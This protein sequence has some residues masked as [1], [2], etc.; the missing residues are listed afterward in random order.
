MWSAAGELRG[1][2]HA[3]RAP[4]TRV[5]AVP[6]DPAPPLHCFSGQGMS[7]A[8]LVARAVGRQRPRRGFWVVMVVAGDQRAPYP[9]LRGG[10]H[11]GLAPAKRHTRKTQ[12]AFEE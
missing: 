7:A 9:R 6:P 3:Q 8:P 12:D 4:A 11:T 1:L 2:A 10:P 5:G